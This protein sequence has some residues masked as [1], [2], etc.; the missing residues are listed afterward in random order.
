MPALCGYIP[1]GE[2]HH[3]VSNCR[4]KP[5]RK[6]Q[7]TPP[8]RLVSNKMAVAEHDLWLESINEAIELGILVWM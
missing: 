5:L 8:G 7:G 3:P 6:S 1:A 4:E 2:C